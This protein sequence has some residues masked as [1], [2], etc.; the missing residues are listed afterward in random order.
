MIPVKKHHR[1]GKHRN[2][3]DSCRNYQP[4][5]RRGIYEF[6]QSEASSLFERGWARA[7]RLGLVLIVKIT[8]Y[9][10]IIRV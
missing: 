9:L 8:V 10:L 5:L 1:K 3:E 7:F 6:A 2:P 4:R